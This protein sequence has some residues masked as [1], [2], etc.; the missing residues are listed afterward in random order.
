MKEQ[1]EMLDNNIKDKGICKEKNCKANATADYNGNG[2]YVCDYHYQKLND[3]FDE[4][5]S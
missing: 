5:Y 3:Y 4:E 2:H 1:E